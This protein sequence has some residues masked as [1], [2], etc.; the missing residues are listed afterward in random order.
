MISQGTKLNTVKKKCGRYFTNVIFQYE[1]KCHNCRNEI[2]IKTDSKQSEFLIV[3]GAI[4]YMNDSIEKENNGTSTPMSQKLKTEILS[5][6]LELSQIMNSQITQKIPKILPNLENLIN[7]KKKDEFFFDLN[8]QMRK[9]IKKKDKKLQ[10]VSTANLYINKQEE[11]KEKHMNTNKQK[12]DSLVDDIS[13][14]I[15]ETL[16]QK[17]HRIDHNIRKA[18]AKVQKLK[19]ENETQN[20]LQLKLKNTLLLKKIT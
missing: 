1:M 8:L 12:L 3:K 7:L 11:P 16:L 4:R 2:L 19:K 9:N 17:K 14:K 13:C 10:N 6:N 20:N 5:K 15:N 18:L